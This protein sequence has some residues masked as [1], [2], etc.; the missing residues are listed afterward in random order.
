VAR[1][2]QVTVVASARDL[3]QGIALADEADRPAAF[4]GLGQRVVAPLT[5]VLVRGNEEFDRIGRGRVPSWGAGIAVPDARLIVVR[6]D[7]T[8]PRRV[9]RHE[10]AHLA[11]RQAVKGRVPRWFDEG[12]AV[13]AAGEFDRADALSLNLAVALGRVPTLDGL[14]RALRGDAQSADVGYALAGNA[15][16][17]L[18]SR[19]TTKTLEPILDRLAAGE[20]FDSAVA[21]STGFGPGRFEPAWHRHLKGR[22]NVGLWLAAGGLWSILGALVIV[23]SRLRRRRDA[24][25]RA[26][27]DQ[28]WDVPTG[29]DSGA[30]DD[31]IHHDDDHKA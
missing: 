6:L 8:D 26:A 29:D 12:Y 20:P 17:F 25:R 11:L 7:G 14:N 23:A 18:G 21:R 3:A 19:T 30:A 22:Y 13:V 9:L 4:V 1:V 24:P 28:G 27:L 16:G 2:G 10:M 31:L 15:V 5:L